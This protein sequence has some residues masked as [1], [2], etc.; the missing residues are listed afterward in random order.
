[1]K[2]ETR[3]AR[4]YMAEL[5][6]GFR[7]LRTSGVLLA[8]IFV[9]TLGNFRDKPL[10]AVIAPVYAKT[11][12]GSAT[13]LGFVV[14]AFGIGA[15]AGS[16]LFGAV[17][18]NWS[19]R[20]TFTIC[21]VLGPLV[22]FGSLA[23]TPP[24]PIVVAAAAVS[25]LIFGPINPVAGSVIQDHTPPEMLGSCLRRADGPRAG[26]H[27][28]G[29]VLVGVLIERAGLIPTIVGMGILYVAATLALSLNPALPGMDARP[30]EVA[31]R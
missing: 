6:E 3:E 4:K 1:V 27:P 29:A 14:G 2:R 22:L 30:S 20:L 13:S 12:F 24:L 15:L 11:I 18:R 17:G 19:R 7:F 21:Y 25:G 5:L 9:A 23:L 28:I 31:K 26:R 10:Q 8:M 16:L